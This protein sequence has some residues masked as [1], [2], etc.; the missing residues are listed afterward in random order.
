MAFQRFPFRQEYKTLLLVKGGRTRILGRHVEHQSRVAI[1]H[2]TLFHGLDQP[3]RHGHAPIFGLYPH[4]DQVA[5]AI[6]GHHLCGQA[7]GLLAVESEEKRAL[8]RADGALL[9]VGIGKSGRAGVAG[10]EGGG[11]VEQG[12]QARGFQ[13][14]PVADGGGAD[15]D[16]I[17][18]CD[19]PELVGAAVEAEIFLYASARI[20]TV[21]KSLKYLAILTESL[22][23]LQ[24]LPPFCSCRVVYSP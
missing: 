16:V 17:Q 20:G 9:P 1:V 8:R 22:L 4:G 23:R 21:A 2:G 7:D 6:A 13:G 24:T 3:L 10:A 5:F 15:E 11:G 18:V 14:G 12:G 19:I